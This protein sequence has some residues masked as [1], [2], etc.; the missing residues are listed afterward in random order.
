MMRPRSG[1]EPGPG[2]VA[3]RTGTPDPSNPQP[4]SG[5]PRQRFTATS[6]G[7]VRGAFAAFPVHSVAVCLCAAP[8]SESRDPLSG[9]TI[10]MNSTRSRRGPRPQPK[11]GCRAP[12]PEPRLLAGEIVTDDPGSAKGASEPAQPPPH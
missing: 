8:G 1:T 12:F 10:Q 2:L 4:T 5:H 6:R 11:T 9:S 7:G 3:A